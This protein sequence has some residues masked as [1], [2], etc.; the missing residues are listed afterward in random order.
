MYMP[1]TSTNLLPK[2]LVDKLRQ[3]GFLFPVYLGFN[4]EKREDAYER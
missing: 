1:C 3:Q 4:N 2:T